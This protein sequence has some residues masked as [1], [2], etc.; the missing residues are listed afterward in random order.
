MEVDDETGGRREAVE[1]IFEIR[2]M[3]RNGPDNNE[4]VIGVLEDRTGK[5]IDERVQEETF[6][7]GME[8]HLLEDI[9]NDVE[10]EG[11]ERVTL[12]QTATALDPFPG[13]SVE[14]NSGLTC[15]VEHFDPG[16]PEL[17]EPFSKEDAIQGIPTDGVKSFPEIKFKNG[18]GGGSFVAALNNVSGIDEVFRNGAPR[19][20]TSLV[21]VD[22]VR[23][24]VAEPQGKAFGVDFEAAVLERDGS[25]IIRLVCTLFFGE[26][27]NV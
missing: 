17:R 5:V 4:S 18:C 23:D 12:P 22:K 27:D 10:K 26:K 16:P 2:D 14:E 9:N 25:K 1:D 19:N 11:G 20:K 6:A 13:Y 7:R 8:D 3:L 21:G 15:L 24:K